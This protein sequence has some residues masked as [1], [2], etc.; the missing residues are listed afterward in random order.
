MHAY[1]NVYTLNAY[2]ANK[3]FIYAYIHVHVYINIY[4]TYIYNLFSYLLSK[5]Y[6]HI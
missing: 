3:I 6:I 5:F 4:K 1:R 2:A